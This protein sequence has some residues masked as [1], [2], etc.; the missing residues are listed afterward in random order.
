MENSTDYQNKTRIKYI[1]YLCWVLFGFIVDEFFNIISKQISQIFDI[2]VYLILV[3]F[4]DKH[5]FI[6]YNTFIKIKSHL[7]DCD[8]KSKRKLKL[9]RAADAEI[10][11][12]IFRRRT[13]P[14]PCPKA[15]S[16]CK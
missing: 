6:G 7:K 10:A 11:V 8:G 14:S 3:L 1:L 13:S 16:V 15:F 2:F 5:L 9:K 4:L 12:R